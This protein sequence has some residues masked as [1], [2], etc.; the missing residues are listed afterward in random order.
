MREEKVTLTVPF[1]TI[2]EALP[3]LNS[4]QQTELMDKLKDESPQR[5]QQK[6]N[7]SSEVNA[8]GVATDYLG[9]EQIEPNKG[10]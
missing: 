1:E 10:R 9:L 3:Y 8:A 2:L 7:S 4:S 5:Y 6:L